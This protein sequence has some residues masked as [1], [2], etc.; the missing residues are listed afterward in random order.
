MNGFVAL[1]MAIINLRG[2]NTIASDAIKS[3]YLRTYI[4]MPSEISIIDTP[5]EYKRVCQV[6]LSLHTLTLPHNQY[7]VGISCFFRQPW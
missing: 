7:L 3:R 6:L 4:V 1:Q 2:I 5:R